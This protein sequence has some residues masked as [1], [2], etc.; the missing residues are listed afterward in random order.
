MPVNGTW[1]VSYDLTS[2]TQR[3]QVNRVF[4]YFNDEKLWKTEHHTTIE[5]DANS[6]GLVRSSGGREWNLDA[7]AGD[8]I[9]LRATSMGG[10]FWYMNFCIQF[11]PKL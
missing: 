6:N 1:R 10:M 9:D 8:T 5:M 11:I 3:G 7:S 4:V 2:V